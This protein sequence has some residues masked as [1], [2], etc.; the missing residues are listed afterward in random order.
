MSKPTSWPHFQAVRSRLETL[1]YQVYIVDVP[2]RPEFPYILLWGG[3]GDP[4]RE[5]NLCE[6][7]TDL[8]DTM[9]VTVTAG[10]PEGCFIV[11][12]RVRNILE[13]VEVD[14]SVGRSGPLRLVDSQPVQMDRDVTILK[15]D[16]N[17]AFAVDIYSIRTQN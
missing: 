14:L 5:T 9:G 7:F 3:V 17:P 10:T 8:D 6:D 4:S 2:E 13:G 16:R 11:Q 12:Q 15:T 1:D